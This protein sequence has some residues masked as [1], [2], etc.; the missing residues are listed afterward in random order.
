[1][2]TTSNGLDP[3]AHSVSSIPP[4]SS[5]GCDSDDRNNAA[6]SQASEDKVQNLFTSSMN[7]LTLSSEGNEEGPS[8]RRTPTDSTPQPTE[9]FTEKEKKAKIHVENFLSLRRSDTPSLYYWYIDENG[10][11]SDK[12]GEGYRRDLQMIK[13]AVVQML[14]HI[15]EN[16]ET[17][18]DYK[19]FTDKEIRKCIEEKF[20]S[21]RYRMFN[22]TSLYQ[23]RVIQNLLSPELGKL[24]HTKQR[25]FE[26]FL[27]KRA[28]S[29][30]DYREFKKELKKLEK[31]STTHSL[32]D[33]DWKI[34]GEK[35]RI[36]KEF[37]LEF[38][39]KNN[40]FKLRINIEKSLFMLQIGIQP[41][42][43]KGATGS[44]IYR[45]FNAKNRG[46]GVFKPKR[47]DPGIMEKLY[48]PFA[49]LF[50]RQESHLST[51]KFAQPA[52]EVGTYIL[53]KLLGLDIV[54]PTKM[55]WL[56]GEE[57]S[58]QVF[59]NGYEEAKEITDKLNNYTKVDDRLL[60]LFQIF[61]IVDSLSGNLDC[62]PENWLVRGSS[63]TPILFLKKID[64]ANGFPKMYTQ[65]G[66][67]SDIKQYKWGELKIAHERFC[68]EAI[69][70]MKMVTPAFIDDFIEEMRSEAP[71]FL[72][73]EMIA[74]LR[75]RAAV[76]EELAKPEYVNA[77]PYT[78]SQ[79][80]TEA[81]FREFFPKS[82]DPTAP[83][84]FVNKHCRNKVE[85]PSPPDRTR[86]KLN[87][88]IVLRDEYGDE[89]P[90]KRGKEKEKEEERRKE[91]QSEETRRKRLHL[92]SSDRMSRESEPHLPRYSSSSG[93]IS[94]IDPDGL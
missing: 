10:R 85:L 73:E 48:S 68:P 35:E 20:I 89:S 9:D 53:A 6:C 19:K 76:I 32:S 62:H 42:A 93:N 36:I 1:M 64:G 2:I 31:S 72:T 66:M 44:K 5:E 49:S 39:K 24:R 65:E 22:P 23:M 18:P 63:E 29:K 40:E 78:L 51:A 70:V 52:S 88:P 34:K 74:L 7:C 21:D 4:Y 75:E 80:K 79:L 41:E 30:C 27:E 84:R 87:G 17:N 56:N 69:E 14:N 59:A 45:W 54:C 50:Q 13:E 47:N 25:E 12:S 33:E 57:G 71:N 90:K 3:N 15:D 81:Q 94:M 11:L 58:F 91:P 55:T 92:Y 28:L 86:T 82:K 37:L 8:T 46:L 60:Y 16:R 43:N 26:N 61:A 38:N 83:L 77:S 67:L